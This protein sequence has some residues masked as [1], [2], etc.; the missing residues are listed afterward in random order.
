M[1]YNGKKIPAVQHCWVIRSEM[2][3]RLLIEGILD[4]SVYQ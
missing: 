3:N 1:E 4:T 2:E